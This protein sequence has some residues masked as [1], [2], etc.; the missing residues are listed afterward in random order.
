MVWRRDGQFAVVVNHACWS[1]R[2]YRCDE[3]HQLLYLPRRLFKLTPTYDRRRLFPVAWLK[4]QVPT[5]NTMKDAQ[6]V[7]YSWAWLDR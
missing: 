7:G 1:R 3:I 4:P 5:R 6:K 2:V